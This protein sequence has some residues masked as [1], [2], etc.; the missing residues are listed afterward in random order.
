MSNTGTEEL[1][2]L[3]TSFQKMNKIF[4]IAIFLLVAASTFAQNVGAIT[5]V[6]TDGRGPVEFANVFVTLPTDS[7]RII[8]GSVT[9]STGRFLL[10]KLKLQ[11]YRLTVQMVGY[12]SKRIEVILSE[13]SPIIDVRAVNVETDTRLLNAVEVK[14]MREIIKKTDDG[15]VVNASDNLTQ[16]GGTAADLLRNMPGILVDADGGITIRGKSPLTLINGRVSGIAGTDRVAQLDRI[17]ASAI[18]R[19][20]IVNNPSARY[21]A[22]GEGGIINIILKKNRDIGTNGAFAIGMGS[23]DRYRVN[24]SMLLN[25]RTEKWN[26]GAAYDNWYTTRTRRVNGDRTNY[27]LPDEHFLIQRRR[28]ERLIFYQNAKTTIDYT[29]NAKSNLSLEALWAFPGEDN[30]ETLNNTFQNEASNFV[31]KNQR[32]SNEIRRTQTVEVSLNYT[33]RF[34][35]PNKL[36]AVNVSNAYGNDRENTDI[37]TLDLSEQDNVLGTSSL[38]RTHTYQ[39]TDLGSVSVDYSQ[40]AARKATIETGYKSILRVLNADFERATLLNN[41]YVIDPK[42]SNIFD[43]NEQI[44]A[45]YGQLTGWTGEKAAPKWKYN[46]GLRAEQVWN[47]GKTINDSDK[48]TN[49]YFNLYPSANLYYYSSDKHNFKFGYSR[50]INRPGLGQLNPFIDIT[51]SLNQHAGNSHLKPEL[52]HSLELGYNYS[53]AK[54]SLSLMSFYRIRNHAILQYA[55]VDANGVALSQ[56]LNFGHAMTYGLEALASRNFASFWSANFSFSAFETRIENSGDVADVAA[57]Q[58][59]W[60]AKLINN[61][62]LGKNTRL[63][64][65]GNYVSPT[66]TPQ[67]R[68]IEI[69]NVDLGFQQ[70]VMKGNGR[71]GL[72]LTDIFNTQR[73]GLYTSDYN[74][75]FYRTVK[76]DTRAVMITFGYTFN[77]SFKEK[78]MENRF[79]ND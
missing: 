18:E 31:S 34:D 76:L 12:V 3:T 40:P 23:G 42:N 69:Y 43:F 41:N 13:S 58:F 11:Q 74:F 27:D 66:A 67:G 29:P 6:V 72:V 61:L 26:F 57:H 55:V 35:D 20:E 39:K 9:D 60:Y 5:G 30:H 47:R 25:H 19:I 32:Y 36:L 46:L 24:G 10:D 64:V 68:T 22:D 4:L 73:S 48:F 65:T 15:F 63:Q 77:S 71:L 52:V 44:H 79:R 51:D 75:D 54:G 49:N 50:R 2:L 38:Q 21:D 8:S 7:T 59:S 14:A 62:T 28:D 78:L 17:P 45:A 53:V 56:P 16:I 37:S 1:N 70:V 33:K